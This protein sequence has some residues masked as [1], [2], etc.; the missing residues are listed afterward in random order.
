MISVFVE[1]LDYVKTIFNF[2]FEPNEGDA[3][4]IC[5]TVDVIID[6]RLGNEP[7]E[8]FSVRLVDVETDGNDEA[9]IRIIDDD[10]KYVLH[11]YTLYK[12]SP[13]SILLL[14]LLRYFLF[15]CI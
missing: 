1:N 6:D 13:S 7:F 8:D 12:P 2:T 4:E 3:Q 9:C 14:I 10:S 15:S 11:L 5:S